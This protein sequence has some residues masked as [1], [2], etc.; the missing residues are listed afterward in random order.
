MSETEWFEGRSTQE[1]PRTWLDIAIE[2]GCWACLGTLLAIA[3]PAGADPMFRATQGGVTVTLYD[4]PCELVAVT[5]LPLKATWVEN[6]KTYE[7]CYGARPD[8]GVVVF[9]FEDRTVGLIP[10][11]ALSKVVGA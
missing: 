9:Y 3:T 7:G 10:F 11:Q 5:N 6:G 2:I 4:D 1:K 8:A